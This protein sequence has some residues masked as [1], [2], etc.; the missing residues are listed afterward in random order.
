MPPGNL[1]AERFPY[2]LA[3]TEA[4]ANLRASP[5]RTAICL[6]V[7]GLA[8]AFAVAAPAFDVGRIA[9]YDEE[10]IRQGVN[11]FTVYRDDGLGL[12]AARCD[13]LRSLPAV[14]AAGGV[15]N[16]TRVVSAVDAGV[17]FDLIEASPGFAATMWPAWQQEADDGLAAAGARVADRLG[18]SDSGF[19]AHLDRGEIGRTLVRAADG[20]AR[21]PE[22]S[23]AV[24]VPVAP[25]GRL[26]QCWV[27]SQPGSRAQVEALLVGW[28]DE[29][30]RMLV[31]A[32]MRDEQIA[33]S[34]ADQLA[35][36]PSQWSPLVVAAV[37]VIFQAAL[38]LA[39]RTEIGLYGLLGLRRGRLAAMV[40]ADF[41]FSTAVPLAA[42]SLIAT[43]WLAPRLDGAVLA[44][45]TWDCL[46]LA[47][48]LPL[49]V[50]A[51]VAMLSMVKPFDAIRGR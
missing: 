51:I 9:A 27:E 31:T 6:V 44:A 36:R 37:I 25:V 13:S 21:A 42:G 41:L 19:V 17:S 39:R 38:W 50:L 8:G 14:R 15:A 47:A 29:P 46:R 45:I 43:C 3:A 22:L 49:A 35:D 24:V 26:A 23:N 18:I 10:L 2:R 16:A 11:L 40:S 1:G 12:D 32:A 28:F 30:A 33:A 5:L 7:A 20:T 4:L 48:L 34:P